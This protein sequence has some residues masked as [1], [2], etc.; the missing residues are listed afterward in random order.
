MS[1]K[2]MSFRFTSIYNNLS[3]S[4]GSSIWSG[5]RETDLLIKRGHTDHTYQSWMPR[6]QV[7][8][9]EKNKFDYENKI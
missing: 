6:S 2:V 8:S 3:F 1:L 5:L 4:D 7:L 9:L